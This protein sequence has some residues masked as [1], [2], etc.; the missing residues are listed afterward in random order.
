MKNGK[1]KNV[2]NIIFTVNDLKNDKMS[3]YDLS[4]KSSIQFQNLS[5]E[6]RNSFLEYIF[7][8]CEL[9]LAVAIDY[10]LSNGD[11]KDRDSLHCS[12]LG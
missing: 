5:F 11:P 6:R 7:G 3:Q 8:G 9:N 1:H 10:T 4:E 12:N 2:G